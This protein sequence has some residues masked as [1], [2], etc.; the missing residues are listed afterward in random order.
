MES[1][2]FQPFSIVLEL[3][4]V[5]LN[6]RIN[7]SVFLESLTLTE[8]HG[9]L[10]RWLGLRVL[11]ALAKDLGLVS[12]SSLTAQSWHLTPVPRDLMCSPGLLDPLP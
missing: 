1:H 12:R 9:G 8:R 7:R 11:T 4:A 6:D 5:S 2:S 3:T 10:E